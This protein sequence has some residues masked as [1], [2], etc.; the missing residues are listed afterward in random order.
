M[1]L[2]VL[3]TNVLVSGLLKETGFPSKII[4]LLLDNQVRLAYDDRIISEYQ[5]V[6]SR[7][8]FRISQAKVNNLITF[9]ELTGIFIEEV[10]D[11]PVSAITDQD[12][13]PFVEIFISSRANAL[14]T[15]NLKHFLPF[16]EH[17]FPVMSPSEFIEKFFPYQ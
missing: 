4:D 15:G 9:I 16:K 17:K 10:E 12:D 14:V 2:I 13:V 7:P 1:I 8:E 5:E 3:D 6:L 11:I